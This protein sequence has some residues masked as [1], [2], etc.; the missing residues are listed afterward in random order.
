[1]VLKELTDDFEIV[2]NYARDIYIKDEEPTGILVEK[3]SYLGEKAKE[4]EKEVQK[5]SK[6][7]KELENVSYEAVDKD[8]KDYQLEVSRSLKLVSEYESFLNTLELET[9]NN[10]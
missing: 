3:I 9:M 6:Y 7:I 5:H 2:L 8:L 10:D 1:M 4:I